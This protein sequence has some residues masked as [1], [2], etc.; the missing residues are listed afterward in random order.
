MH[1]Q[2][3]FTVTILILPLSGTSLESNEHIYAVRRLNGFKMTALYAQ[4]GHSRMQ[5]RSSI[6]GVARS[7]PS[8]PIGGLTQ[9]VYGGM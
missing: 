8:R 9:T 7:S 3:S 4:H 5:A 6:I 1:A 2:R